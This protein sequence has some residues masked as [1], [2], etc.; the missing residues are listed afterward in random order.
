ML[1]Q[2]RGASVKIATAS[3]NFKTK[4]PKLFPNLLHVLNPEASKSY[5][6]KHAEM[7]SSFGTV[8]GVE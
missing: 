2:K 1:R 3:A 8:V 4:T 5:L 6:K 7:C